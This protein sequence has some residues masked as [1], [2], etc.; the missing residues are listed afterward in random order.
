MYINNIPFLTLILR[1]LRFSTVFWLKDL[2][3]DTIITEIKWLANIYK[4]RD[5]TVSL[6]LTDGQFENIMNDILGLG[7]SIN[8]TGRDEHVPEVER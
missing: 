2:K 6:I 7:I 3:K 1:H 8:I 5:F 4:E